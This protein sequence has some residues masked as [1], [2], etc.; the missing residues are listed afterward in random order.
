M[1]K[2]C[3]LAIAGLLLATVA[4]AQTTKKLFEPVAIAVSDPAFTYTDFT[5]AVP[6]ATA[7]VYMACEPGDTALISGSD[8]PAAGPSLI[9]DNYLEV[10]IDYKDGTS[11]I[12]DYCPNIATTG[13][14]SGTLG[15]PKSDLGNPAFFRYLPVADQ[16]IDV[17]PDK[18]LYT[19]RLMDWGYTK[20]SSA[21]W[22]KTGCHIFDRVCHYDAGKKGYKTLVID[23]NGVAA[24][25]RQHTGDYLGACQVQ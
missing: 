3:L 11:S 17:A 21:V 14:F 5:S 1:K 4:H 24:H 22:L 19:L 23:P 16:P 25:L 8:D 10:Q 7:Q 12:T 15:D 6:F 20:A 2:L 13:C 9:I 18:A